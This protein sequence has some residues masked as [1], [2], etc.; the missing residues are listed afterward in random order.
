MTYTKFKY[1]LVGD[2]S[3]K[4]LLI[5]IILAMYTSAMLSRPLP[6]FSRLVYSLSISLLHENYRYTIRFF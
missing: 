1:L 3:I 6:P 2:F 4:C 5:E